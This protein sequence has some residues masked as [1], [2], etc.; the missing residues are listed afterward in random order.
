MLAATSAGRT[1]FS[2]S[3]DHL[4]Q[5]KLIERNPG[6]GHPLRPEFRLT[7]AGVDAAA[8]AKA[9]VAAVPDDSKFKL[10]RKTW[11]VPI[12][13]LTGTPHR[14]SMLKS[15]LMT[16]TDRAL[17]SSLHELE[18]VDW[19]KREIETSV[20]MPFPIYRAVSTGLTVNQAVGL[21]L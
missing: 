2:A 1:A 8:I 20:R 19:I 21:P 10:L 16:I 4:I 12:L 9:I 6:H 15:N 5:L 18:D 7:P 17:S 14:F 11:T 13:A 3:L